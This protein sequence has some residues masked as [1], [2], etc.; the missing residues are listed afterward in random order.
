MFSAKEV[1]VSAGGFTNFASLLPPPVDMAATGQK[2]IFFEL[3]EAKQPQFAHMLS[4][5]F[6][7]DSDKS[8]VYILPQVRYPMA[9]FN[10]KFWW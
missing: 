9:S 2:I 6:V 5:I 4:I 3:D 10:L 7:A 1:L 8:S